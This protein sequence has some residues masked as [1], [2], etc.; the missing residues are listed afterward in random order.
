[1]TDIVFFGCYDSIGHGLYDVNK[2]HIQE[3]GPFKEWILDGYFPPSTTDAKFGIGRRDG[4]FQYQP[5]EIASV[6]YIPFNG[7]IYTVLA[8]W[9]RSIDKRYA[10]NAAFVA[11][12]ELTFRE[13]W[14]LAEEKFP[15]IANR[16]KANPVHW[17]TSLET[18]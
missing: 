14:I 16:L 17:N 1:M 7:V 18:A 13:M 5:E 12:E 11:N 2:K 3:F 4:L 15:S 6:S 10:A 9:D 8:M